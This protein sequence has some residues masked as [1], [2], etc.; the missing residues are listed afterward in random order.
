MMRLNQ[1]KQGELVR[2]TSIRGGRGFRHKL[3]LKGITEG[4]VIRVISSHGPITIEV[5]RNTMS[6]GRGM[7]RKIRVTRI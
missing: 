4:R 7:A 6:L 2:I 1:L 5:D 3:A